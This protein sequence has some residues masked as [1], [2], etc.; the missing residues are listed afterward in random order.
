MS[1]LCNQL[2]EL[3][4]TLNMKC[5]CHEN[6]YACSNYVHLKF[7][8]SYRM[9]EE[10]ID[11]AGAMIFTRYLSSFRSLSKGLTFTCYRHVC[12]VHILFLLIAFEGFE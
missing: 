8:S 4:L 11:D 6:F 12:D 5:T 10:V 1:Q 2:M 7:Y 9:L 3:N